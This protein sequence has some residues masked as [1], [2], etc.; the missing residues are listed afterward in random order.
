VVKILSR[1]GDSLADTYDVVGSVAGIETLDSKDVT[2]L[3]EMGS[4]LFSE[5]CSGFVRRGITAA[6]NQSTVFD[7]TIAG[8][9]AGMYRV[10]NALVLV[11]NAARV[12]HCNIS[13]RSLANG[14]EMPFFIFDINQDT[15]SNIRLDENGSGVGNR[16]E[17]NGKLGM[18][19]TLGISAGQPQRVGEDI[20]FRGVTDAFGAGTVTLTALIYV[21][22]SQV[23]G[24]SSRGLPLPAW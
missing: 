12:S 19:P 23:G 22:F 10:L 3:H 7:I 11:T 4:T 14:R 6:L 5:R 24:I 9:P 15:E 1:S 20:L 18:L 17:L 21:G 2:L 8:L 13:L 16:V